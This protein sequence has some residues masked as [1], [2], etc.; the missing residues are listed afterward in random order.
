MHKER[1][2][3]NKKPKFYDIENVS[4]TAVY[5]DDYFR[6]IYTKRNYRQYLRGYVDYNYT[7]KPWVMKPFNKM[8]SDTAKSTKYLRWVKEFNLILFLQDY[9][10]E[11]KSTEITTNL[12]SEISKLF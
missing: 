11:Q 6:D 12:S 4:V 10:S 7:F 2:N 5:N 8:I 1:V 3:P 9:L